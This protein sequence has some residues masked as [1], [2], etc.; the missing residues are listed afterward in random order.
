MKQGVSRSA[1]DPG[2]LWL[3]RVLWDLGAIQFGDFT[4][5]RTAVHSPIYV[6]VRLLVSHPRSLRRAARVIREEIRTLQGMRHPHV[7]PFDL[8][9]GVP[10]GGLHIATAYSLEANT[11]MIYLHPARDDEGNLTDGSVIEG[12]YQ[13]G[14]TVLI[15]DDLMTGGGSVVETAERLREAGLIVK[16]AVVLIDREQG[17][18]DYLRRYGIRLVPVLNLEV[19]LNYL[20]SVGKIEEGW[21]QRS[22]DYLRTFRC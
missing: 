22:I 5:G 3:A 8:V 19:M 9:A 21:Y 13:P 20:M 4:M 18:G 6:N 16:D 14:Q 10:F 1:S 2:N 17:G 7:A 15:I 11:P 12:T